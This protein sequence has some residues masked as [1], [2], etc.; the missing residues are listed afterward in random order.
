MSYQPR[1]VHL[2]LEG[3]TGKV[4]VDGQDISNVVRSV[5]VNCVAG[6]QPRVYLTLNPDKVVIDG[7]M[8][9]EQAAEHHT[10]SAVGDPKL[11]LEV[12]HELE[13]RDAIDVGPCSGPT[14]NV[15]WH[16]NIDTNKETRK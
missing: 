12:A 9:V 10:A 6:E 16:G 14:C 11:L 3:R 8:L 2:E 5:D 7:R 4:I 15:P 13:R 1:E